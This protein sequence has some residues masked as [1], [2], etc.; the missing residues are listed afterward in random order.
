MNSDLEKLPSD[1][2]RALH[3]PKSQTPELYR[4]DADEPPTTVKDRPIAGAHLTDDEYD[5]ETH[6]LSRYQS[7]DEEVDEWVDTH[8]GR[9]VP[10]DVLADIV[11]NHRA[12]LKSLGMSR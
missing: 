3:T 4:D 5:V 11:A 9:P 12:H 6:Y 8:D 7:L 1:I 2:I 10:D